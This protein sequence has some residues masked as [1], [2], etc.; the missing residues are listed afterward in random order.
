LS[1]VEV[2]LRQSINVFLVDTTVLSQKGLPDVTPGFDGKIGVVDCDVD[3]GMK[4]RVDV[5][6]SIR[7]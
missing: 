5:V 3:P 6:D 2:N 1:S 7:G 4:C